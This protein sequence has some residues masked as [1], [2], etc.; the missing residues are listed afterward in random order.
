MYLKQI[1]DHFLRRNDTDR[2]LETL[3]RIVD[4]DPSEV[5]TRKQLQDLFRYTYLGRTPTAAARPPAPARTQTW[6]APNLQMPSTETAEALVKRGQISAA[7]TE[8]RRVAVVSR[9]TD[10]RTLHRIADLLIRDGR[11]LE[12][13]DTL[14]VIAEHYRKN[15]F[16]LKATAVYKKITKVE[17]NRLSAYLQLADLYAKQGLIGEA[18]S[19]YAVL[20]DYYTKRGEL[21][22]AADCYQK[23]VKID[24]ES[25]NN[26]IQLAE[27]YLQSASSEPAL[28][29]YVIVTRM[30]LKRQ[31]YTEGITVAE[32]MLRIYLHSVSALTMLAD[33]VVEAGDPAIELLE[34]RTSG[35][36]DR[37]PAT[38]LLA[39]VRLVLREFDKARALIESAK[40]LSKADTRVR[41]LKKSLGKK[42]D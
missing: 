41:A 8:Y 9:N 20:A 4:L 26:H 3:T 1:A 11:N 5:D 38:L 40:K 23:I 33:V 21:S 39:R 14:E 19:Q 13:A 17:P 12:A 24:P 37:L 30:L 27:L 32:R 29:E 35:E 18:R 36:T 42:S 34:Q 6:E 22:A 16:F 7:I 15:G 25:I 31:M 28:H 10:V 2:A